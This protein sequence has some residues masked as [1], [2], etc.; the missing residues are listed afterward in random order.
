MDI[1]AKKYFEKLRRLLE[2]CPKG[3]EIVYSNNNSHLFMCEIDAFQK[4]SSKN[5]TGYDVPSV[6]YV[7]MNNNNDGIQEVIAEPISVGTRWL[8][9]RFRIKDEF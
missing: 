5:S 9:D 8:S 2:K 7:A 1:Q 6:G 3:Y 4:E